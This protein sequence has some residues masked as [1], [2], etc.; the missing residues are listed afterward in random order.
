MTGAWRIPAEKKVVLL[1]ANVSDRPFASRLEWNPQEYGLSDRPFQAAAIG[2][3]G[4]KGTFQITNSPEMELAAESV[5]AWE[6][7]STGDK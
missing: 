5:L 3:D 7:T 4:T 6:I 1:F 2:P